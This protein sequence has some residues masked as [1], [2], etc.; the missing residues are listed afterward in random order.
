MCAALRR[1]CRAFR[2]C[3]T[4]DRR[5]RPTSLDGDDDDVDAADWSTRSVT[6]RYLAAAAGTFTGD[7]RSTPV[8]VCCCERCDSG[9]LPP[10]LSL[11]VRTC[12]CLLGH[13]TSTG[14]SLSDSGQHC[15]QWTGDVVYLDDVE[16]S[17]MSLMSRVDLLVSAPLV[18]LAD[19]ILTLLLRPIALFTT[20]CYS[21]FQCWN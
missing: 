6:R 14:K 7:D 18:L 3:V 8:P 21:S 20:S 9:W 5:R 10:E 11:R 4:P 16:K 13:V 2:C 15:A 1:L 17:E 12:G 19:L